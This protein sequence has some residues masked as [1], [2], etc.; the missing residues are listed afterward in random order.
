[1]YYSGCWPEQL[2]YPESLHHAIRVA[3]YFIKISLMTLCGIQ[4]S[5]AALDYLYS[6]VKCQYINISQLIVLINGLI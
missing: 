1:M 2:T 5:L 6:K 4:N 3:L